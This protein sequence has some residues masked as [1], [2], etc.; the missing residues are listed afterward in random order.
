VPLKLQSQQI[1]INLGIG[2]LHKKIIEEACGKYLCKVAPTLYKI[3]MEICRF[4]ENVTLEY[5]M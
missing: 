1:C 3:Q 5:T 4:S 2:G